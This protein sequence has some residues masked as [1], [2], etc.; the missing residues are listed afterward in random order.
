MSATLD[1]GRGNGGYGQARWIPIQPPLPAEVRAFRLPDDSPSPREIVVLCVDGATASLAYDAAFDRF[2]PVFGAVVPNAIQL[3]AARFD[4]DQ[5]TDA[6]VIDAN[7]VLHLLTTVADAAGRNGPLSVRGTVTLPRAVEAFV[8]TQIVD[9]PLADI[10]V[11]LAPVSGATARELQV[12]LVQRDVATGVARL[13]APQWTAQFPGPV[14][15]LAVANFNGRFRNNLGRRK[16]ILAGMADGRVLAARNG[17]PAPQ[18]LAGVP[19]FAGP[20]EILT[21]DM[22]NDN[23]PDIVVHERGSRQLSIFR[24]QPDATQ[25][26]RFPNPGGYQ[27]QGTGTFDGPA[28]VT[29]PETVKAMLWTRVDNDPCG[30]LLLLSAD[31]QRVHVVL[32]RAQQESR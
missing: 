5:R 2:V 4:T 1:E 14:A 12:H 15:S 13:V 17:Q 23:L 20:I 32:Q 26:F 21:G 29:L 8:A 6:V 25:P 16:W 7:N 18:T 11:V 31:G 24:N 22:N 28:V 9:D 3:A 27:F 19:Q 30:D 10:A